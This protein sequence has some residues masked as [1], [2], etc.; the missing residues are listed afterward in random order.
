MK[1]IVIFLLLAIFG[2]A[3]Y[4]YYNQYSLSENFS[5]QSP[6][7]AL[8]TKTFPRSLAGVGVWE[9][10]DEVVNSSLKK[11]EI[12]VA[13][14][15]AYDLTENKFTYRDNEKKRVPIASLTKIMTAIVALEN[16]DLNQEIRID[17]K[18]AEV[19]EDSMGLSVGE[20]L[21]MQELL[22]GLMLNS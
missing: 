14:A 7:P 13:A 9:P 18:A 12:V 10:R 19:G 4:L 15:A 21:S 20:E 11:P 3:A 5:I 1:K 8:L 6:L 22:Y 17:K 16:M 2:S